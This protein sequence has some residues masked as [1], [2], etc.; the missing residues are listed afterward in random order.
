M[1]IFYKIVLFAALLVFSCNKVQIPQNH[2]DHAFAMLSPAPGS[3]VSGVVYFDDQG[4]GTIRIEGSIDGLTPG[5]HGFH[6]HQ[7]GDCTLPDFSMAG[8]HFNPDNAPHGAPNSENRH[9]GDLGNIFA[10][11]TGH[12]YLNRTDSMISLTGPHCILGRAVIIH[13]GEDDLET[14][15]SGNA[16]PRIACGIVAVMNPGM[17]EAMNENR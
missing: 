4:D 1:K 3:E 8:G 14:Q 11:S 9:V 5:N 16:G 17:R 7:Y 10:D 15:P 12:A 6:I 2:V 13:A